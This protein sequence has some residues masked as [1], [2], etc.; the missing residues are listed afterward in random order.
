MEASVGGLEVAL[1]AGK[2]RALFALLALHPGE[3]MS[4]DRLIEG[5]WGEEPPATAAKML[6]VYISQLRKAL[7]TAGAGGAILTRA[8]G[9]ELRLE[10]DDC[11]ALRFERLL[12]GGAARQAL[13]LWRGPALAD[14]VEPF[15]VAEGRREGLDDVGQRRAPPERQRLAGGAAGQ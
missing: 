2:P 14:V 1:G 12:A 13:A 3:A 11:D 6:Q 4:A 10:G 7:A 15:A 5:I 8:H 9:Y